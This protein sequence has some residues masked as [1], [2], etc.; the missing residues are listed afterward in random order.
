VGFVFP[1]MAF[2][3]FLRLSPKRRYSE[4]AQGEKNRYGQAYATSPLFFRSIS[5]NSSLTSTWV[6]VHDILDELFEMD[7]KKRG[8]VAYACD[9]PTL[10]TAALI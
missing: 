7:L 4:G 9:S 3:F 1:G 6:F 2:D 8:L 10:V 5:T